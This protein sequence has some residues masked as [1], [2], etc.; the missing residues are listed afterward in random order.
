M[1]AEKGGVGYPTPSGAPAVVASPATFAVGSSSEAQNE[2]TA[3]S[4]LYNQKDRPLRDKAFTWAYCFM[5]AVTVFWGIAAFT[6]TDPN[7]DAYTYSF[8]QNSTSC[9]IDKYVAAH[10]AVDEEMDATF[11]NMFK[12]TIAVWLPI[13]AVL[14]ICASAVYVLLFRKVAQF[15]VTLTV[16]ISLGTAYVFGIISLAAGAVPFGI[17][18]LVVAVILSFFYWS[19][20]SQLKMCARLLSVAGKGLR[21][22]LALVPTALG[23]KVVG[24]GALIY[25]FAAFICALYVGSPK[26]VAGVRQVVVSDETAYCRDFYGNYV[27][28]CRWEVKGWSSVYA[29][30]NI[31]TLSWTSMLIM[32][33]KLYTVADTVSQWYFHSSGGVSRAGSVRMALRHC[34][35]N[36]FGSV[37]FAAAILTLLRAARRSLERASRNNIICCI[38]NCIAQPILAMIEKFSKFATIT[39]AITGQGFVAAAKD[40][41]DLLKRNFM[42]TYSVWW[43]PEMV[44]HMAVFLFSLTWA[45]VVFFATVAQWKRQDDDTRFG[46]AFAAA[47]VCFGCMFYVLAFIASLLLNIVDTVYICY[48]MDRDTRTITNAEVHAIYAEVPGVVGPVVENPDGGMVYGAPD[49]EQ[50]PLFAAPGG[51]APA[52]QAYPPAYSAPAY[53]T[54]PPPYPGSAAPLP[55]AVQQYPPPVQQYP[56][57]VQQYPPPQYGAH[58]V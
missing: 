19:I 14:G 54:Y 12:K 33:I 35:V 18:L 24:V 13:T 42:R 4:N 34:L 27:D 25:M 23:V 28:C 6:A 20:R 31:I 26:P 32:Q 48:A 44:L 47:A 57:P 21:E 22:N 56:P 37:A 8:Y 30:I 43:V 53:P 45:A 9:D 49:R 36:S 11:V 39:T 29:I 46:L 16:L 2:F 38:I 51:Y 58:N 40:T 17:I 50:Q 41:F 55:A 52:G 1:E 3:T 10:P 5:V 15:M 7:A